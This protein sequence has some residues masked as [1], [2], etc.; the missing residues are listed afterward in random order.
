[1]NLERFHNI[2]KTGWN[3][4]NDSE[5]IVHFGKLVNNLLQLTGEPADADHQKNVVQSRSALLEILKAWRCQS[6]SA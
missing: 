5:M 4:I 1:M 6:K 2:L 3:D